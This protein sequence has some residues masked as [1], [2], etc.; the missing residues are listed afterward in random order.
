MKKI[1]IILAAVSI[2]IITGLFIYYKT[3]KPVQVEIGKAFTINRLRGGILKDYK[4]KFDLQGARL[5][6]C[7]LSISFSDKEEYMAGSGEKQPKRADRAKV[8]FPNSMLYPE[9]GNS[10]VRAMVLYRTVR[11]CS[12]D[13]FCEGHKPKQVIRLDDPEQPYFNFICRPRYF[14]QCIEDGS[15]DCYYEEYCDYLPVSFREGECRDVHQLSIC[16]INTNLWSAAFKIIY[17]Q[18]WREE[19]EPGWK[20]RKRESD[21]SY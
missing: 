5:D 20:N 17:N 15:F 16:L 1:L 11:N 14:E 8:W 4:M 6:N 21:Y 3:V 12:N 7:V 19:T 18:H 13:H 2:L 9:Y 10:E